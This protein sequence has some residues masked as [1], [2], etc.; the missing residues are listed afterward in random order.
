M[1]L[2]GLSG[3]PRPEDKSSND[4]LWFYTVVLCRA[5]AHAPRREPSGETGK[6]CREVHEV[7]T[8]MGLAGTSSCSTPSRA[9]SRLDSLWTFEDELL[10]LSWCQ[11][12]VTPFSPSISG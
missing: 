7:A 1:S 3:W 5:N 9:L 2:A 12:Q 4:Q 11:R 10:F 8:A 6:Q